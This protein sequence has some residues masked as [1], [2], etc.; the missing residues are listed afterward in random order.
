MAYPALA[1]ANAFIDIAKETGSSDVTPMKVQKL[2]YYAHG[3]YLA[4]QDQPLINEQI[5][6]WQY[7][8]VV[9]SIY[10]LAKHYGNGP[11]NQ[12]LAEPEFTPSGNIE[13]VPKMLSLDSSRA[14]KPFLEWIWAQYGRF[15]GTQLSNM[16]H[17]VDS[18]WHEV[19]F[20]RYN[21]SVPLG[22]DIDEDTIRSYFKQSLNSLSATKA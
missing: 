3:W 17:E 1:V 6:A 14:I 19:V 15:S 10:G 21:G 8:P 4:T 2:V 12:F 11:I 9:R 20:D 7:G 22:T 18:P 13:M 5:E 16:T